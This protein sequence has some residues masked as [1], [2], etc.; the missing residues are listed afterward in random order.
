MPDSGHE[1][2]L[3]SF[4]LTDFHCSGAPDTLKMLIG[5]ESAHVFFFNNGLL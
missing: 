2:I 1:R 5:P 4:Y 3:S